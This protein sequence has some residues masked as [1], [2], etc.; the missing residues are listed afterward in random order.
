MIKD[1]VLPEP[2]PITIPDF[3][4]S[5]ALFARARPNAS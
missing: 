4:S 2:T 3:T 5:T 1:M